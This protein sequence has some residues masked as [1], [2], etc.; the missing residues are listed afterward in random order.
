MLGFFFI[1]EALRSLGRNA[2]PSLAA[3]ATILITALVLGLFIPIVQ[4]ATGK[5]NEIRRRIALEVELKD[6]IKREQIAK[7][8]RQIAA[9]PHVKSIQYRSE[10][11]NLRNFR[12]RIA[13]DDLTELLP[14]NP[15]PA[16]IFVKLDE[17][18]Y[19]NAVNDDLQPLDGEGRRQPLSPLITKVLNRVDQTNKILSATSTL[20][21]LLAA[22]T[23]VLV[24]ASL[25]LV[26]N[27]IRLSI[28]SRRRELE[29][30]RLVGATNWFIR[31]PFV[32][33]G[34]FVGALGALGAVA[35]LW[36]AKETVVDPLSDS[37]SLLAAPQT[38]SFGLLSLLIL[39]TA[40]LVSA[41]GSGVTIRRFLRV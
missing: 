11:E 9:I 40:M 23:V 14:K 29:V 8:E 35:I 38:L 37:F 17:A 24:L 4:A 12:K 34:L 21:L 3:T 27:T 2:A 30:M 28:F 20:K 15:I 41:V 25:L 22:L 26:G 10:D 7:L 1:R 13:D 5:T 18:R 36:L 32:I 16:T 33:E 6:N 31:W 39:L 19:V